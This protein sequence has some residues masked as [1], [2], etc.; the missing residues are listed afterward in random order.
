[1]CGFFFL[2]RICLLKTFPPEIWLWPKNENWAF[3][4]IKLLRWGRNVLIFP[5]NRPRNGEK[6]AKCIH[7]RFLCVY[8]LPCQLL[9]PLSLCFTYHLLKIC[10]PPLDLSLLNIM[11]LSKRLP[12]L[13]PFA[14]QVFYHLW[15]IV[16]TYYFRPFQFACIAH[17][18]SYINHHIWSFYIQI[19]YSVSLGSLSCRD[20][21]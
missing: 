2:I 10:S 1:M 6:P 9:F 17:Y 19:H 21:K 7:L 14:L 18:S 20:S 13:S 15:H 16:V 5:Y 12:L 8:V 3:L 11:P 4:V